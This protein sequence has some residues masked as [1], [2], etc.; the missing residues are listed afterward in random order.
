[1]RKCGHGGLVV[2]CRLR[3]WRVPG[4]K[5]DSTEDPS[6]I[7]PVACSI[8]CR[9][10]NVLPLVWCGSLERGLPVQV[11]SSSSDRDSK[12]RGQ[13]QNSPRFASKQT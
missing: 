1:M 6:C 7:G 9:R 13:S 8:I 10:S 4:S 3:C 2:R 5:P 11:S 12:L